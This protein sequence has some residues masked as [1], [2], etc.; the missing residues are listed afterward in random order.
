MFKM[1]D[2]NKECLRDLI[3]DYEVI[4]IKE[5][6]LIPKHWQE[7]IDSA[8]EFLNL[9]KEPTEITIIWGVDKECEETYHFE[10]NEEKKA[11]VLGIESSIGWHDWEPKIDK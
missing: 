1:N 3:S 10:S 9:E 5:Y 7:R 11:F 2:Y 6:G 8:K 4:I